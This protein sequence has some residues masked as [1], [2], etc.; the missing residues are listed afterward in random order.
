MFRPG[1]AA[2]GARKEPSFVPEHPLSHLNA[3][4][5]EGERAA[6][7]A[8]HERLSG[9]LRRL[10]LRRAA[11]REELAE[12]LA[13]RTWAVCWRAV[14]DGKYDAARAA[15]ST[16]VY[17]IASNIWLE[18]LRSASRAGAR[19]E[20]AG[21]RGVPG[22]GVEEPTG[23]LEDAELL[24]A[25][26][27]CVRPNGPG[28]FTEEERWILRGIASGET[29]RSMARQLRVAASTV[30]ARKR[31]ALDRM[32]RYLAELGFRAETVERVSGE[33]E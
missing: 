11:G 20:R 31:S 14:T 6:F 18:H 17:A 15:F 5:G 4:V 16:F 3:A 29:D 2:F 1:R 27:S 24:D 32:R 22:A 33:P 8:L 26:R 19:A 9:G 28:G 13:Q 7:E 30:N 10:F 21:S 23:A 25:V 12:E